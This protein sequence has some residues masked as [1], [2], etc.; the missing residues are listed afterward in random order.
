MA[1]QRVHREW[2]RTV[3]DKRKSCPNCKN[4]LPQ[5]EQIWSWGE[6]VCG[7]WRTVSNLCINCWPA[8]EKRLAE[9]INS[10]GCSFELV[11]YGGQKLPE[12]LK[13]KSCNLR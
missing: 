11:S 9:H 12:W 10:C 5:A 1:R 6:Y 3:M 2:F 13:I 4:K 7:K 8:T